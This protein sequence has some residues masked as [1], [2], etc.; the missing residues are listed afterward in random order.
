MSETMASVFQNQKDI[1]N[2]AEYF[3]TADKIVVIG[4]YEGDVFVA[5][6]ILMKCPSKYQNNQ[7]EGHP[8]NVPMEKAS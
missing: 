2:K 5:D 4:K 8:S 6:K 1:E 7:L 3:E